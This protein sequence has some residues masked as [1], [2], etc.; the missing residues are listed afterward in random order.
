[1]SYKN[2]ILGQMLKMFLKLE[3]QKFAKDTGTEHEVREFTFSD[4]FV[5]T[6]K[7]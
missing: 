4:H 3:L 6:K 2:I 7:G 5:S 1:M